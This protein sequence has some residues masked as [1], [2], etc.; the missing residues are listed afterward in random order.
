VV[1][2]LS[3]ASFDVQGNNAGVS[4]ATVKHGAVGLLKA[5]ARDLAPRVRVNGVAPGGVATGLT[6]AESA[7]GGRP[8]VADPAQLAQKLAGRTLLG[9]GADLE[10]LAEAYLYLSSE[11]AGAITG[12]ILRVDGGLLA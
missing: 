1:L 10:G 7:G 11:A 9:H 5:L 3:D 4:Y 2:T 6:V 12:Q 8:V